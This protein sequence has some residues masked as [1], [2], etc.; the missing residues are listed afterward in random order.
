[1]F[2]WFL[3]NLGVMRVVA[4]AAL[5]VLGAVALQAALPQ[6]SGRYIN[7][8][9]AVL[10]PEAEQHLDSLVREVEKQTGAEIAVV[11]TRTLDGLEVEPYTTALFNAWGIGKK[12]SDNG[13]LVL[14]APEQRQMRIEV[15]YGL[16]GVLPDGLAGA[17]MRANFLP[18]F[19]QDQYERGIVEGV[20]RVAAVVRRN[21]VLTP[22][23]RA[24]FD[25]P[26]DNAFWDGYGVI[27]RSL[28]IAIGFWAIG[29]GLGARQYMA[30]VVGFPFGIFPLMGGG[31]F[32]LSAWLLLFVP[33]AYFM[34][35]AGMGVGRKWEAKHQAWAGRASWGAAT[36]SG[37]WT[38]SVGSSSG[39]RSSSSSSGSFG[40]GRSGG[41]GAS[42]RW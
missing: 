25:P 16:E 40:G 7:D 31:P 34:G 11:T 20:G 33:I 35:R 28:A 29:F 41:G 2:Q 9:A 4:S 18:A 19:R 27:F 3:G 23:Q 13:V 15:G 17:I 10:S 12:G 36:R 42:G 14:V 21:Q 26:I 22:A 5:A 30:S 8:W 32:Y 24:S 6:P 38:W 37:R 39:S 1:M